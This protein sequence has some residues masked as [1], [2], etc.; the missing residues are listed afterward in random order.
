M[1]IW[2]DGV[3]TSLMSVSGELKPEDC[4]EGEGSVGSML[5]SYQQ[6]IMKSYLKP[7]D[8]ANQAKQQSPYNNNKNPREKKRE[9]R[10]RILLPSVVSC[11]YFCFYFCLSDSEEDQ[12]FKAEAKQPHSKI[13]YYIKV[14][15]SQKSV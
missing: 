2:P 11:F 5:S 7:K 10:E 6:E 15:A 9:K 4:C 8:K 14:K 3:Y 13:S 12:E 1:K